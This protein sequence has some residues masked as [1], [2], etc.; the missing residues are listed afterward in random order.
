MFE[1]DEIIDVVDV[2]NNIIRQAPRYEVHN[3]RLMHR[4]VH[5]LVFNSQGNLF[6]QKRSMTKDEN[7]GLWDTSAAG[8]VD[9][10]EDYL[11]CAK[12]ELEEE[13]SIN[14]VMVE[15][16]RIPAQM[17]SLWEHVRVYK[18]I[19]DNELKINCLEIS[20]GRYWTIAEIIQSIELNSKIFTSTFHLIFNDYISKHK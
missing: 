1:F 4:S 5:I 13:L 10:G 11:H 14:V 15:V 8:H 19:T 17:N 12:R 9:S 2:D 16:M 18:C 6:L 20:E 7:P 3:K